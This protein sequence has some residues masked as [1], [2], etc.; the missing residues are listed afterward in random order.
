MWRDCWENNYSILD[1]NMI[2]YLQALKFLIFSES[3]YLLFGC[4][5]VREISMLMFQ[6][7]KSRD[8]FEDRVRV[9]SCTKLKEEKI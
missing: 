5:A 9:S 6:Y 7:K 8:D 2:Q 1:S 3:S 4:Q